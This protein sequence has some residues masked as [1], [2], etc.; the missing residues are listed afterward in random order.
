[1]KTR[2]IELLNILLN[3]QCV[4]MSKI[5]IIFDISKRTLFYDLEEINYTISKYGKIKVNQNQ[6]V[7]EGELDQIEKKIQEAIIEPFYQSQERRERMLLSILEDEKM[8]LDDFSDLF[9]V[10]KSTIFSDIEL[11]RSDL[12]FEGL[13]LIYN[14]RYF[15]TGL[16]WKVRD[17]YLQLLSL[18]S[19]DYE[20]ILSDVINFNE[21]NSLNL[22]DYSLFYLSSL[23]RFIN[24]RNEKGYFVDCDLKAISNFIDVST[25]VKDENEA[26]YLNAYILSLATLTEK[27]IPVKVQEYVSELL[28]RIKA[29]LAIDTQFEPSFISSLE[30]HLIA[31][32]YRIGYGFPALNTA[33]MDIKVKYFYLFLTIKK[34]IKSLDKYDVFHKMRDE[35]IGFVSA[36]L[37][38]VLYDNHK[39]KTHKKKVILV[40][41]QGRVVS[42]NLKNQIEQSYENVEIL[43]TYS[44]NQLGTVPINYDYIISTIDLP[45]F[46]NVITVQPILSEYDKDKLSHTFKIKKVFE[47]GLVDKVYDAISKHTKILDDTGLRNDLEALLIK[48]K[49]IRRNQPMLEE[50]IKKSRIDIVDRV[51]S[52]EQ[53]IELS[54][55]PLLSE[56]IIDQ[57]YIDAMVGAIHEY[58]PYIVLA[59]EFALPHASNQTGVKEVAISVLV[60]KEAVDMKGKPVRIFM[61]LATIDNQ[62]HLKALSSLVDIISIPANLEKIKVGTVDEIYTLFKGGE[63]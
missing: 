31:S 19:F 16:E 42:L 25:F 10:T 24:Q 49:E 40:C 44:I 60:L 46:N 33:L 56:G 48:S 12:F 45:Y 9:K 53:A 17:L 62:S 2:Q 58:G 55:A 50:L 18:K 38:G 47:D 39:F 20:A 30:N 14:K 32:Y 6:L 27:D 13:E 23:I 29:N 51:D 34:V 43:G 11:I 37:G 21:N 15:V 35:E 26:L 8:T 63:K 36:Y 57:N 22:S 5:L 52:W 61:T 3:H 59:D 54:S 7:I 1:M 4:D 28:R 41:P